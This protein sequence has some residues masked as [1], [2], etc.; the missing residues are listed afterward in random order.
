MLKKLRD[1]IS[2]LKK[3][4]QLIKP[5]AFSSKQ[6]ETCRQ[7]ISNVYPTLQST[8]RRQYFKN[9]ENKRPQFGSRFLTEGKDVFQHNAWDNVEWDENQEKEA[10]AKV[11]ANSGVKFSEEDINRY[12]IEANSSWDSF[13][14]IHENKFFKD[15]HW[16]FTEFPELTNERD[17]GLSIF[18]VGCGVGNTIFPILQYSTNKNLKVYGCDFSSKAINI[19]TNSAVFDKDRCCVFTLDITNDEWRVPF[20]KN[21]QDIIVMIFVLSAI[22]PDKFQKVVK[23]IYIYLK[24]GGLLLFRD[25][26]RYDMAQLR[27]KPGRSLGKNFYARGDGTRVYFFTQEEI[28]KLMEET[29]FEEEENRAD[30]R[31]QVNRGKLLKMYRIWIQAKYRK[32]R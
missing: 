9:M 32:P 19:V 6:A 25:Y 30:K 7:I 27:F 16:L 10:V 21:S 23:N 29:G 13:Y 12:E 24:P 1:L 18:E 28:K 5:F 26:G 17:E 22:S 14:D 4:R 31:L 15:R 11:T 3:W 20:E 2:R 8:E